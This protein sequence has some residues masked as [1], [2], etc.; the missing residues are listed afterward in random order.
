MQLDL[1]IRP[2]AVSSENMDIRS[3]IKCIDQRLLYFLIGPGVQRIDSDDLIE[4]LFILLAN[5]WT[6]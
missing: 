4:D 1:Q 3:L 6:G 5:L 2:I